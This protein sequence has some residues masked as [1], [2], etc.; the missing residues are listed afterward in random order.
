VLKISMARPAPI[1][2]GPTLICRR[3]P[4]W[5][6]SLPERADSASMMTVSGSRASPEASGE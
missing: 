3:G 2:T 4:I 6:A 1:T 5:V